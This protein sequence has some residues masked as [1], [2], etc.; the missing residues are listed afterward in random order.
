MQSDRSDWHTWARFLQNKRLAGLAAVFL[1][2]SGP[3]AYL[4]AQAIYLG[5]PFLNSLLPS[6][7]LTA[8]ADLLEDPGELRSF[9]ALLREE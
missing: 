3:L 2:A 7:R 5:Q 1:E 6:T 9:V 8:L 4:G